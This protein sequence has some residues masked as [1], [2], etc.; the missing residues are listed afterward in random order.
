MRIKGKMILLFVIAFLITNITIGIYAVKNVEE[1]VIASAQQKLVSD[2]NL[3]RSM[4]DSQLPGEWAIIEGELYKGDVPLYRNYELVDKIGALTGDTVTIFQGDRRVTT[5]VPKQGGPDGRAVD[6]TVSEAVSTK[7]LKQGERFIGKAF[8]YDTWNQT[9]YEPIKNAEGEII[10]IWYVGVP[11]DFYDLMVTQFKNRIILMTG[12]GLLFSS[13][14]V[15]IVTSKVTKPL[16]IMKQLMTTAESGNLNVEAEIKGKDEIAELGVSFNGMIDG[17]RQKVDAVESFAR[18]DLDIQLEVKSTEDVLGHALESMVG[19][20]SALQNEMNIVIMATKKGQLSVRADESQFD[21]SWKLLVSGVNEV[22]DAYGKPIQMTTDYV[23]AIGK[24]EIPDKI[25]QEYPGEY[26]KIRNSINDCIDAMNALLDDTQYLIGDAIEGRLD[27]RADASKHQGDYKAIIEG[28]NNILDAVV[29]PIVEAS[30]VLTEFSKGRLDVEV[31]GQYAGDHAEIKNAL[32]LTI[33]TIADYIHEISFVLNKMAHKD[34]TVQINRHYLGDFNEIKTSINGISVAFN[35][36]FDE[37]NNSAGEISLGTNEVAESAQVLSHGATKQASA[38]EEMTSSVNKVKEQTTESAVKAKT[39]N[40]RSM[41]VKNNA[42]KGVEQMSKMLEAMNKINTSSTNISEV[43]K[44][45]DEIAFQTNIL[46]LNAAVEA[47]RAGEHG[48]GFA[49]VAQEVRNLAA[50]SSEAA[51][52]TAELIENSITTVG[53]GM[54]M[55]TETADALDTI[56]VGIEDVATI[57]SGISMDSEEQATTVQ[58][59]SEG[60]TQISTVT[61]MNEESANT[62]ASTSEEMAAQSDVLKGMIEE[63]KLL[64]KH[65]VNGVQQVNKSQLEEQPQ[66][67]M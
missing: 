1:K 59:M 37:I 53:E 11:N 45:I 55:T 33:K 51:K 19:T 3:G 43:V 12:L 14:V 66:I 41:E 7:V 15:W 27:T 40:D 18:G 67:F 21:G 23:T 31:K 13:L 8:V 58:Q 9:A 32:N 56:V 5:N 42:V 28:V 36:V 61:Q 10:G 35:H 16:G 46:A 57:V 26:N 63:F 65:S 47:A 64:K 22:A 20:L 34:L 30:E 38:I 24:G 4:L 29:E 25:Q 6:T 39:A 54:R 60:I 48:K 2:M 52:E 50:R 49:V 44:A 17:L 62:S